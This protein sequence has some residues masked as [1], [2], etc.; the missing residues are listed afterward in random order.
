MRFRPE[1][2]LPPGVYRHFKGGLYDVL[3]VAVDT[4]TG[5]RTVVYI[6][7]TGE[8]TGLLRSRDAIMF[9]DDVDRPEIPYRG[10]RFQLMKQ[11]NFIKEIP[12]DHV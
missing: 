5:G 9:A 7:Q 11:R 8:Y 3:G 10:P 12:E 6:P 1:A 2:D 4:E